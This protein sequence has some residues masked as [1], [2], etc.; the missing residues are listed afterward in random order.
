MLLLCLLLIPPIIIYSI[1]A[2]W[3]IY[4]KAGK[5]GWASIVP[6]YSAIILLDIV[7]K[8]TWWI[9]LLFIP[10]VNLVVVILIYRVG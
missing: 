10:F 4:E 9:A 8:P 3:K 1:I 7:K 6:V 2:K 5:P